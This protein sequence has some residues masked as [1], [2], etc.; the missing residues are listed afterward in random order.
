MTNLTSS[1]VQPGT[2]HG[3]V[4]VHYTLCDRIIPAERDGDNQVVV[5]ETHAEAEVERLDAAEMRADALKDAHMEPESEDDGPWIEAA[6]LHSDGALTL[7]E[8]EFTFT[9]EALRKLHR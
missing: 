8:P 1:P 3:F 6:V 4:I 9:A 2:R 5:Y 7:V